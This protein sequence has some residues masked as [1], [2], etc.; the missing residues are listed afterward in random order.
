M[1]KKVAATDFLWG[2][3]I[4][5]GAFARVVHAR[6]RATKGAKVESRAAE[7]ELHRPCVVVSITEG[8]RIAMVDVQFE[9]GT[10]ASVPESM[11]IT[12][13]LAVKIMDKGHIMKN[14][15]VGI[16]DRIGISLLYTPSN[17]TRYPFIIKVEYVKQ[18][19]NVLAKLSGSQWI[20]RLY[21]SFQVFPCFLKHSCFGA[22]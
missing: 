10:T 1:A 8:E 2:S 19:K 14:D 15:K 7:G 18:E 5:E 16:L 3:N 4:G 22:S 11:V 20:I 9:D 13:H 17:L 21:S 12:E 6:R